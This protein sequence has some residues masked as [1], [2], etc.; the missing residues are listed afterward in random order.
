MA[1]ALA[2]PDDLLPLAAALEAALEG[3]DAVIRRELDSPLP[4]VAALCAHVEKYRGKMLRPR[5]VLLSHAAAS[6]HA[7]PRLD[8]P[9]AATRL[10]AV[11]ETIHLA[12]LIHDD[13]L[14]EADVRR[15]GRTVN[16]MAGNETAV[17]LGD[18]L[19]AAAYRLCSSIG[20]AR[21]AEDV[22]RVCMDT[23][24]GE[25]L[26]LAHRRDWSVDEPTY[27]AIVGGKT[28]ALIASACRLGGRLGGAGVEGE[29]ALA[30]YGRA[31]GIAFQ[32]Q[33][34]LL[35]LLGSEEAV[36]KSVG[37]DLEKG[38]LTLPLIEYLGAAG[39]GD[40]GRMLGLIERAADGGDAQASAASEI[41]AV[42]RAAGAIDATRAKALALADRAVHELAALPDTPARRMLAVMA[43]AAVQRSR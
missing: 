35:D 6:G 20:D 5:L 21:L 15:A 1:D 40:R 4:D 30:A 28:G 36:G 22:A 14:D 38:K 16:A 11:F 31:V 9:E 26:Q 13:V 7:G 23:A 18:Y 19:I 3:V 39:P 8:A 42:L 25:I 27:E 17:I 37:K 10:A 12:T 32:I 29:A 43:E 2:V 24:E 33:D 34:D 41:A